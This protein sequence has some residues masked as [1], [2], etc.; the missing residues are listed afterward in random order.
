MQARSFNLR[1]GREVLIT[2]RAQ[3]TGVIWMREVD[4]ALRRRGLSVF[5]A[6]TGPDTLRRIEDGGLAAAVLVADDPWLDP[7]TLLRIIRSIDDELPCWLVTP[8]CRRSTLQAAS[9]LRV[10]GVMPYPVQV[11][12]LALALGKL[13]VN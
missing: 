7:L 4:L 6:S 10:T 9:S 1:P 2:H 8:D 11:E 12:E 5:P 3:G 13:V